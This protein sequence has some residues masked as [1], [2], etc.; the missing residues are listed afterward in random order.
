MINRR[1]F[2]M[3]AAG[4]SPAFQL[5]RLLPYFLI[6]RTTRRSW[7]PL[8]VSGLCASF[9]FSNHAVT[10]RASDRLQSVLASS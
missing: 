8:S 2:Q 9:S 3:L 1:N 10:S 4:A 5:D 6:S 7:R